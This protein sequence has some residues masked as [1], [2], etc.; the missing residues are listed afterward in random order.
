MGWGRK[1]LRLLGLLGVPRDETHGEGVVKRGYAL[2]AGSPQHA[3]W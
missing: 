1:R 3:V 2:A